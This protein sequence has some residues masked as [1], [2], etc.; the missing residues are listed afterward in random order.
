[1]G[2]VAVLRDPTTHMTEVNFAAD[3]EGKT[4]D[5]SHIKFSD[6]YPVSG[7][8]GKDPRLT[9]GV[10]FEM[11][12]GTLRDVCENPSPK[13]GRKVYG[14]ARAINSP[15]LD[16]DPRPSSFGDS[17]LAERAYRAKNR[18]FVYESIA[19]TLN[20]AGFPAV[21][22]EDPEYQTHGYTTAMTD[23]WI[24]GT[25]LSID[26][27]DEKIY[28]FH[29]IEIKSPVFLLQRRGFVRCYK[30]TCGPF[31]GPQRNGSIPFT[32]FTA[33]S[34]RFCLSFRR[35]STLGREIGDQSLEDPEGEVLEWILARAPPSVEELLDTI[36]IHSGAYNFVNLQ[37]NYN[38][39]SIKRTIEFRQHEATLDAERVKQWVR[40][41]VGLVKASASAEPTILDPYLRKLVHT[42][43]EKLRVGDILSE[44]GLK[45]SGVYYRAQVPRERPPVRAVVKEL[46]EKTTRFV[47][48]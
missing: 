38:V 9:F 16:Y 30:G 25:D 5:V 19:Q 24:I 12:L 8:T 45:T 40:V 48:G 37:P 15:P 1:M 6:T 17:S 13:D 43:R 26:C 35:C 10:E 23:K 46:W 7:S 33:D 11:A 22:M 41:C 28:D 21:H 36:C 27:P 44:L 4:L 31:Y 47:K 2:T 3:I 34:T 14:V 39:E 29:K 20:C 32:L 18:R 42:K